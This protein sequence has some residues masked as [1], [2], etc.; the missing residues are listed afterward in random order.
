MPEFFFGF[1]LIYSAFF[2]I[3]FLLLFFLCFSS[4]LLLGLANT[5]RVSEARLAQNLRALSLSL[6]MFLWFF[7]GLNISLVSVRAYS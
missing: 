7:A 6:S 1:F 5:K 2:F 3:V 4:V